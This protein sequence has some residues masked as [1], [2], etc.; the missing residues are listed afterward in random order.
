MIVVLAIPVVVLSHYA[1]GWGVPY[2]SF[3][4]DRGGKCTNTF[5]GYDCDKLTLADINWWGNVKLPEQTTVV[6]AHYESGHKVTLDAVVVVPADHAKSVATSLHKT[7][8]SCGRE[9]PANIKVKKL[10]HRCTMANLESDPRAH[11]G[12]VANRDYVISTGLHHDGS[13]VVGI[14]ETSR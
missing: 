7:F 6:R 9:R 8:G 11:H 12:P 1:G 4:T 2:F 5:T 14:K 13:R 10:K 3:T